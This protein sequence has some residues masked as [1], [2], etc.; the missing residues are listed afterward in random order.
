MLPVT[1]YADRW[2]VKQGGTIRFH[3]ATDRP[4]PYSARVARVLCGDPNP[5]GPGYREI[6]MHC[7]IEGRHQGQAQPI[8]RGSFIEVPQLVLPDDGA[9][10][11]AITLLPTLGTDAVQP[12]LTLDGAVPIAIGLRHGSAFARI[13]EAEIACTRKLTPRRWHDV[14]L[15]LAG[16]VATLHQAPRAPRLDREEAETATAPIAT[17]P[18]GAC[19]LR[20]AADQATRFTGKLER[21]WIAAGIAEIDAMLATQRA[22]LGVVANGTVALW[23]F[24]RA[25]ATDTATDLGPQHADGILRNLPT[26]A[27]TGAAWDGS[28][29]RWVENPAHYGAIHF[30]ADDVGDLGWQPSLA[31]AIPDD[32]PSGL[33]AL[34]LDADGARDIIPFA[35]RARDPGR[36]ARVALLLPTFTY[37]IYANFRRD[38]RAARIHAHAPAWGAL[39]HTPTG[40]PEYGLSTY[41]DHLD[42]SGISIASMRR[43][44]IDKRV[45]QVQHAGIEEYESGTYWLVADSYLLD[46]LDRKGIA[47]EVLTDH[48]LQAEGTA[49]LAPYACVLTGQHPEYH[50]VETWDAIA[51]YIGTGGRFMYMGGNGFYWK[52]VPHADGPWALEIRRAEGGIR[53][54]AAE[55]GEYF[56]Q[57]DGTLG[58]LWRRV[59]RTP[60]S[61]VGV[62]FSTQGDYKAYP[63]TWLDGIGDP[64]VAFMREGLAAVPGEE[65]G[66]RG[67][68]G[69]G[70]AGHELDRIDFRLGTPLHAL[71]VARAVVSD[72]EYH[73]VNEERLSIEWPGTHEQIIRSDITF[74]EAAGGGAV[75]S[76]GSMNFV[77]AL[78]VDGYDNSC[79]KLI[80]NVVRRFADPRPFPL[81][82]PSA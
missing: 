24:S 71:V 77:G 53:V 7:A 13:G 61:L 75:F 16:G 27:V 62:G 31:L 28:A 45:N 50:T 60:Q 47:V 32:W 54:W 3:V 64:R 79:A 29:H 1:G 11:F 41:D 70:A 78:P 2:S 18:E 33:Y 17:R 9:L 49:A 63:Y 80:E 57:F 66:G 43:P 82:I 30:H 51:G 40:H 55:P 37:Q 67:L 48:D 19:R 35:V 73:P 4:R 12:L 15:V 69:G 42:G 76:V 38:D 10:A 58:G 74:F 8:A 44:M 6:A 56:H 23:D 52:V 34:H 46:L 21:P 65:F 68:M 26:R 5:A 72:P 25:I 36:R 22:P 81:P 39:S 20:I 59:G 14:V